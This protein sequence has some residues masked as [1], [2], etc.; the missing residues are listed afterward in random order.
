MDTSKKQRRVS[1]EKG[2]LL[3][4]GRASAR[5]AGLAN[6]GNSIS[7]VRRRGRAVVPGLAGDFVLHVST[8]RG[9]GCW[10]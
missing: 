4:V 9:R 6:L 2:N 1:H 3:V 5:C 7:T 8:R 10:Q